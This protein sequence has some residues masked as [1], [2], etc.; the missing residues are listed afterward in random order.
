MLIHEDPEGPPDGPRAGACGTPADDVFPEDKMHLPCAA[1]LVGHNP[2]AQG[3]R[4]KR[5]EE[6]AADKTP[7]AGM[8]RVGCPVIAPAKSADA[9]YGQASRKAASDGDHPAFSFHGRG[10]AD[11][12]LLPHLPCV[13]A[14]VCIPPC[15]DAFRPFGDDAVDDPL[16]L[17]VRDEDD[18]V[19]SPHLFDTAGGEMNPV[20]RPEQRAH[21]FTPAE[22]RVPV[23]LTQSGHTIFTRGPV[24][25]SPQRVCVNC[26]PFSYRR[27]RPL[28]PGPFQC[29]PKNS[30][31]D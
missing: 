4:K 6:A 15:P 26:F 13:P 22:E 23:F 3:G 12:V 2:Q 1:P 28:D 29:I 16:R 8:E 25:I 10:A 24:P 5:P 11:D 18:D 17:A 9:G 31:E 30:P 19:P 21:A 20:T 27:P 14:R 7:V